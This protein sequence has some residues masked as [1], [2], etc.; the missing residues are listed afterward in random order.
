M[1]LHLKVARWG[2]EGMDV[3][4][5]FCGGFALCYGGT[6]VVELVCHCLCYT[7]HCDML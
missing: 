4:V 2:M 6:A 5:G 1:P 3:R 7:V